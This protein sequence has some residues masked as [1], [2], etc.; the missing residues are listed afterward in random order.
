MTVRRSYALALVAA[1][2]LA[3]SAS[4]QK[5]EHY[6]VRWALYQSEHRVSTGLGVRVRALRRQ[7][8]DLRVVRHVAAVD[9]RAKQIA[10]A[11][12]IA[13]EAASDPWPNCSDPVWDGASSWDVTVAC[14]NS[15][16]WLDSP[17]YYR[18]GL[19]F[20]PMWETRFGRLCP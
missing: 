13:R 12:T 5:R 11:E 18:C 6:R 8:H 2:A 7:L 3:A 15:G 17:G 10:A 14:E 20:D 9:W 1:V 4:A 16:D 19:Q